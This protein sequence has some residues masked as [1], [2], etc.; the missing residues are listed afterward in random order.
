MAEFLNGSG[1]NLFLEPGRNLVW[2]IEGKTALLLM[3]TFTYRSSSYL[4]NAYQKGFY[5]PVSQCLGIATK[6]PVMYVN[7]GVKTIS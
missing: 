5:C 2:K 4:F 7:L 1:R 3:T 6:S